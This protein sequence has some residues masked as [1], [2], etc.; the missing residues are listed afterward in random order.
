MNE[1]E[2]ALRDRVRA[3]P[4][5]DIAVTPTPLHAAPRLGAAMG[6]E[7]MYIKRDDLTGLAF[8]G[9]KARE[10]EYILAEAVRAGADTFVAGGGV[11]QSNHARQCAAAARAVG[12]HPVLVLRRGLRANETTGNQLITQLLC[13]DIHWVEADAVLRDRDSTT[14]KMNEVAA[15]LT[16]AG[17]RPW[18]LHSSMHALAAAA[19]VAAGI[20]IIDQLTTLGDDVAH[21]VC[22]SM[23]ATHVGLRIALEVLRPSWR[24]TAIGWRPLVPGLPETLRNLAAETV[25]TLGIEL[26]PRADWFNTIDFGGPAYGVP[27]HAGLAAIRLAARTEGLLLDPVYTGKGMA[28]LID[29]VA[30][31]TIDGSAAPIVFVH[32]GGAPALF[33]YGDDLAESTL[34]P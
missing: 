12:L 13:D 25:H 7:S 6:I 1:P 28:G 14:E 30:S 22:T 9:N 34:N 23:G 18:V 11:A 5:V 3:L 8:G 26:E 16:A 21:I 4:R 32:T 15:E 31:G 33:A 27:S 24:I 29:S 10:L 19:Y 2:R 17:R 20:E